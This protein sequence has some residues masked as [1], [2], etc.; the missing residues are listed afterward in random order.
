M[1]ALEVAR[2]ALFFSWVIGISYA[3]AVPERRMP[4][5]SYAIGS[6][7]TAYCFDN[8]NMYAT[9]AHGFALKLVVEEGP[10]SSL[11]TPIGDFPRIF[12]AADTAAVGICMAI[13]A[14]CAWLTRSFRPPIPK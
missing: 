5:L 7:I 8:I 3:L 13:G 6:M 10:G 1:V 14:F 9:N 12:V 4:W 2:L 11:K